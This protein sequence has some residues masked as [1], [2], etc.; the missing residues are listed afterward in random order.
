MVLGGQVIIQIHQWDFI[1]MNQSDCLTHISS[2]CSIHNHL[3]ASSFHSKEYLNIFV[4]SIM[5]V[6]EIQWWKVCH[7][8]LQTLILYLDAGLSIFCKV[9]IIQTSPKHYSS[10]TSSW[11][12]QLKKYIFSKFLKNVL[13]RNVSVL[14]MHACKSISTVN[15][16]KTLPFIIFWSKYYIWILWKIWLYTYITN[17]SNHREYSVFFHFKTLRKNLFIS[18][19][20]VTWCPRYIFESLEVFLRFPKSKKTNT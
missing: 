5:Y 13:P 10:Q 2:E 9:N 20:V 7:F 12:P 14:F 4:C 3:E 18:D 19:S 17:E 15:Y 1:L 16:I 11:Y 8:G 6:T